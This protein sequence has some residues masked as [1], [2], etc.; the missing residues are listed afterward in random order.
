MNSTIKMNPRLAPIAL[1]VYNRPIHTAKTIASLL[2]N[3]ECIA[4]DLYI[5]SDGPGED[6]AEELVKEVRSYCHSIQGFRTVTI[7]D[8]PRNLGLAQSVI[9][10]VTSILE[11]YSK[12]IVIEDDMLVSQYFLH[13][14]NSALLKYEFDNE[15]MSVTG[16]QYPVNGKLPDTFFIRGADCWG[17][18]TWRRGWANF[19]PNGTELLKELERKKLTKRFDYD[20][21]YPFTRMLKNQISGKNNSWAIRWGASIFLKNGLMLAPGKSMLI[22]IGL[23]GT[24]T[25][26]SFSHD[27][28]S[29]L[30][31]GKIELSNI[32]IKESPEARL[33]IIQYFKRINS[34]LKKIKKL[35]LMGK[36]YLNLLCA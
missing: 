22:N 9:S 4:S 18:G 27:F 25:H 13:F 28:D 30:Y 8:R 35:L 26:C 32:P 19:N 16:Y 20:G 31:A 10:G 5:F 3:D 2:L 12:I 34:P 11:D 7:F 1:F 6:D 29:N 15:V 33:L 36:K 23:D 17:W 21:A 14:M 24:G